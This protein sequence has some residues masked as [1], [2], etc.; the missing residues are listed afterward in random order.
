MLIIYG[1]SDDLVEVEGLGPSVVRDEF[2]V[3]GAA[4]AGGSGL[5]GGVVIETGADETRRALVVVPRFHRSW[6]F[7]VIGYEDPS[8]EDVALPWPVRI[9]DAVE[10]VSEDD[11]GRV[12]AT[13]PL[14]S[15]VVEVD[16]PEEAEVRWADDCAELER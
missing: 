12:S 7:E 16:A 5:L 9:R 15:L 13:V 6:S 8:G 1:A 2:D 11:D 10:F 4:N 14:Y 3:T